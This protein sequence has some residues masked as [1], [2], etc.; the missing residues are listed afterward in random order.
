MA[1][2]KAHQKFRLTKTS[3][4]RPGDYWTEHARPQSRFVNSLT[5][6][7]RGRIEDLKLER[8]LM[9]GDYE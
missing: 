8:E 2:P 5:P 6:T 9:R 4:D 7:A 3:K 1:K